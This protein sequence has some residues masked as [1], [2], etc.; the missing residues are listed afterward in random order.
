MTIVSTTLPNYKR[1]WYGLALRHLRMASRLLDSGFSDGAIFHT[2]HAYECV[3]SA[4]I[5]AHNYPV[6]PEG[7]TKLASPSRK[8]VLAYPSPKGGIQDRSAHKARLMFF[9]ELADTTKTYATIHSTLCRYLTLD[10]RM[11]SL[12]YDASLDRLP[13]QT[14][15]HPFAISLIPQVHLFAHE[16]WKEIR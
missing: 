15:G 2:Y 3:L 5:A 9:V 6:P 16:V 12:Y 11:D 8:S 14:Y 13:H 4:F 1:K 10:V 7:W